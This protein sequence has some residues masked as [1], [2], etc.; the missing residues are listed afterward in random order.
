MAVRDDSAALAVKGSSLSDTDRPGFRAEESVFWLPDRHFWR[1]AVVFVL[2]FLT[3]GVV[4]DVRM[5]MWN[6]EI[7]TLYVAQQGSPAAILRGVH[8]GMDATPPL[9]PVLVSS[10]LPLV[11]NDGLA[12]RLLSTLG[13]GA[14]LVFVLAF[15]R[16]RLPTA[17][18]FIAA[19]LAVV[20]CAFYATEGRSYGLVLGCAAGALYCWQSAAVHERRIL[21]LVSLSFLLAFATALIGRVAA[22]ARETKT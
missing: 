15:C 22:L 10:I 1:C 18:A 14:M 11:W 6:D 17:Y 19:L 16:R 8:D 2:A 7:F 20:S 13:F 9:Y 5:K 3:C 4:T 12:V 21:S